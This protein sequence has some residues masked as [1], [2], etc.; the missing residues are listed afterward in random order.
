MPGR[1]R[2][3]RA[4]AAA[5][6]P[7]GASSPIEAYLSL[8]A[9][10]QARIPDCYRVET[11]EALTATHTAHFIDSIFADGKQTPV[12]YLKGNHGSGKTRTM[13]HIASVAAAVGV[14]ALWLKLATYLCAEVGGLQVSR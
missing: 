10:S 4:Q 6:L 2:E 8:P 5:N 3:A 14:V 13:K 12:I 9:P 7:E 11:A 1:Y